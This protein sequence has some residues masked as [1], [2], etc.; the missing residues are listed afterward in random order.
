MVKRNG[1]KRIF[2]VWYKLFNVIHVPLDVC[3]LGTIRTINW[4]YF[5]KK[6]EIIRKKD[7]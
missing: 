6:N 5:L 4:L 1:L 2:F 3:N 7:T